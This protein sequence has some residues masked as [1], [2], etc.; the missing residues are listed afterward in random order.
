MFIKI[1][2]NSVIDYVCSSLQVI[3]AVGN[4]MNAGNMR[5]GGAIGFRISFLTQVR[6]MDDIMIT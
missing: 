6:K 3:L 5:V 2:A 1:F 4:Y